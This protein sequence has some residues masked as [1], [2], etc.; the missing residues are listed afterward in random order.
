MQPW[1]Y[2]HLPPKVSFCN[3]SSY[4]NNNSKSL[5]IYR[6]FLHSFQAFL[7]YL[8]PKKTSL[9]K[10][11]LNNYR[12][13]SNLSLI[14]KITER[15]VKSRLNDH[16][17]SNSLYNPNKSAYIKF[18]SIETALLSLYDHLITTISHQQV[19]CLC[20]LDL[21]AAFDTFDSILFHRLS[22]WLSITDTAITWFTT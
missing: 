1:P 3:Y 5:Y 7:C 9:D 20:H 2:P 18:H 10:D 12:H 4:N 13:K 21:S 15:M 22:S 11:T 8:T 19:F 14:S 17:S 16:L 6:N